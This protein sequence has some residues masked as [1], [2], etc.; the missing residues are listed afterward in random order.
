MLPEV[1]NMIERRMRLGW[2]MAW[3]VELLGALAEKVPQLKPVFRRRMDL[4]LATGQFRGK[5][6][7]WRDEIETLLKGNDDEAGSVL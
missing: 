5:I 7:A 1:R 6:V 3:N 4:L 2:A